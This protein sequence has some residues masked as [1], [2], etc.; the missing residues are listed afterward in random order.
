MTEPSH[1]DAGSPSADDVDTE[2]YYGA[3]PDGSE[4]P[5]PVD[6]DEPG[7][8]DPSSPSQ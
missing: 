7:L 6:A 1:D 2:S 5:P 4:E 8:D 3:A